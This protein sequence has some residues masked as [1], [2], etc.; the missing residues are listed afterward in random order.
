MW[1]G[2]N[3]ICLP[4]MPPHSEMTSVW[5]AFGK[6][7]RYK[8][9]IAAN[10][11][12][13]RFR[14]VQALMLIKKKN[15][16]KVSTYID[17]FDFPK[18]LSPFWLIE[19]V[20]FHSAMFWNQKMQKN[21]TELHPELNTKDNSGTANGIYDSGLTASIHLSV[22]IKYTHHY[23]HTPQHCASSTTL[24]IRDDIRHR[25]CH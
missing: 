1:L 17:N 8:R 21:T 13:V 24:C 7:I 19:H 16:P 10:Q 2:I 9:L 15:C 18:R 22:G 3:P 11:W 12:W 20:M 4:K 25:R 23:K 14:F 6:C 5:E